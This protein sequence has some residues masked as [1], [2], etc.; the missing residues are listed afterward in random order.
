MKDVTIP[1]LSIPIPFGIGGIG[2]GRYWY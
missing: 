2:I 1:I